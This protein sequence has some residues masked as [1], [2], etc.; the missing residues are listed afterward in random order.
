MQRFFDILF[1]SI[2]I[3]ILSPLFLLV[4]LLLR[5]SGEGYIFFMQERIGYQKRGFKLYK[6]VTMLK[7]SENIGTGTVTL[8]NDPRI[9]PLGHFLRKS[10]IN[11]LPQLFNVLLGHMSIIGPRPQTGR[12]FYAFPKSSQKII[13]NVKPGLSGLGSIVFRDEEQ[14][15]KDH[16]N[17]DWFYDSVIMPY[18]GELEHWYVN[19]NSIV[20]YFLLIYFTIHAVIFPKSNKI[21]L[22]FKDLP[23]PPKDLIEKI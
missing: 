14:I 18:K 19:N 3:L 5:F 15:M 8:H 16:K 13:I 20:N 10:K 6:F 11:E 4:I 23:K 21:Y 7:N 9:L 22:I 2:A 12:C 1:S 17:P